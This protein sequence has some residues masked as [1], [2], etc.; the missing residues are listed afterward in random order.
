MGYTAA[1]HVMLDFDGALRCDWG[2]MVYEEV[3]CDVEDVKT[4]KIKLF[5][6]KCGQRLF[7]G[8]NYDIDLDCRNC[9]SKIEAEREDLIIH[10]DVELVLEED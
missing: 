5:C 2:N 3:V 4:R 1:F 9:G 8:R 7:R 6:P 10:I